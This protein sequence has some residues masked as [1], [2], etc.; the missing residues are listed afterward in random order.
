MP[1]LIRALRP[2]EWIKNLLVFAGVLFS[3]RLDESGAIGDALLTFAAFCA[4][5][6]AGYLLNDLRDREHDRRHPEKRNRPIASGAVSP[7]TAAALAAVLAVAALAIGF[8]VEPEV[9]GLVALYGV[10]T[11]AYSLALKRLV[12][13]DVMTIASLFILRVVAGAVAVGAHASE[14]LLICTGM[15]ALFLGFT[16]RRQEAMLEESDPIEGGVSDD[17]ARA[18]ALLAAVPRSDDR[19]GDRVGDHHLRHLRGRLAARSARRCSPPRPRSSTG[20]SATCT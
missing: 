8:L 4:I 1:P 17:P 2:Q 19:D 16:K 3:G 5:A 20:S 11:T 6:S 10:I 9:A 13:I 18:R 14:F 7:A 15:L 12:I